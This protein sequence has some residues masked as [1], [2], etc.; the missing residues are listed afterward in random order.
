MKTISDIINLQPNSCGEMYYQVEKYIEA[1]YRKKGKHHAKAKC[2]RY[3]EI[4]QSNERDYV[5][6]IKVTVK[7]TES[8]TSY[9][10][11]VNYELLWDKDAECFFEHYVINNEAK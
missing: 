8:S 11:V 7:I 2:L 10:I 3:R 4:S 6:S 5:E 9:P 1:I